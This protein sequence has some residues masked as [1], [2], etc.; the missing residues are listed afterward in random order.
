MFKMEAWL[1]SKAL[2]TES[3]KKEVKGFVPQDA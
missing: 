3:D 1:G 2:A